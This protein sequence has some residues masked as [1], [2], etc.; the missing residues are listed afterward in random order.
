MTRR[1]ARRRVQAGGVAAGLCLILL[2]GAPSASTAGGFYCGGLKATIVGTP[3]PDVIRGTSGDDVIHGRGGDDV[4]YGREGNDVICGGI[5]D[6]TIYGGPGNDVIHGGSGNDVIYGGSGN[7]RL[8]GSSGDDRLYGHSGDDILDGG[9]GSDTC[10]GGPGFDAARNCEKVVATES[11][12]VPWPLLRP[13]PKQVALTFDD[14]PHSVY[15][16]R[17]LDVLGRHKVQATFFVIGSAAEKNPRLLKRMVNEGHSVQNHT[18]NHPYLTRYSDAVV[19]DQLNRA[20]R[21]IEAGTG[22]RPNCMRPPFGA[23]SARVRAVAS[24]VGLA[25]IMWDVDP[26]DWKR[27]GSAAVATRVLNATSGGDIIL[28]HDTAGTSTVDALPRII[29]GLRARG[30]EFVPICAIPGIAP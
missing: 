18:Y 11:G 22:S 1:P 9:I 2:W 30:Y 15:T 5:G 27:P 25:T 12:Q 17:I 13:G 19:A 6:D 8:Y 21:I 28:L 24:G 23:I 4:I 29:T 20:S 16:P 10:H 14:G 26:W 3:G 7:D